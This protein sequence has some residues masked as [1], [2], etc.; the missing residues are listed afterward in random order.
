[1]H[2]CIV[3]FKG[4]GCINLTFIYNIKLQQ[5]VNK[6]NMENRCGKKNDIKHAVCIWTKNNYAQSLA[7]YTLGSTHA[8]GERIFPE[9]IVWEGGLREASSCLVGDHD[10]LHESCPWHVGVA[11]ELGHEPLVWL[12]RLEPMAPH[13][14]AEADDQLGEIATVGH[15]EHVWL[16]AYQEIQCSKAGYMLLEML[17]LLLAC[18]IFFG[19]LQLTKKMGQLSLE[20]ILRW[21]LHNYIGT[22]L[23]YMYFFQDQNYMYFVVCL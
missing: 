3:F 10:I 8:R 17:Y 6:A 15:D 5:L 21:W 1:M 16:Q 4:N 19:N 9:V 2:L 22:Y 12:D 23:N 20:Q 11:E 14:A 13:V 7:V 18:K